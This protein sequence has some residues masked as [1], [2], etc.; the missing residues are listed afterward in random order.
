MQSGN[1]PAVTVQPKL[2]HSMLDCCEN[3]IL[4]MACG[5][6]HGTGRRTA[7]HGHISELSP[8]TYDKYHRRDPP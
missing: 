2:A 8:Y 1:N 3:T 7:D 4:V 6:D 5:N